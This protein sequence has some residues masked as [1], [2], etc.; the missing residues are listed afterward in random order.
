MN[1][2]AILEH[3][4]AVSCAMRCFFAGGDAGGD[5]G[6]NDDDDDDDSVAVDAMF[7]IL[8]VFLLCC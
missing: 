5:A 3:T 6:D 1:V 8:V 2:C 7:V 4:A